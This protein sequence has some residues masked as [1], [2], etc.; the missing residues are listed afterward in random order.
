MEPK[1]NSQAS[2]MATDAAEN[3]VLPAGMEWE[4][5]GGAIWKVVVDAV[6]AGEGTGCSAQAA[7]SWPF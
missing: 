6:L 3:V 1:A 2:P 4:A 7:L 5:L